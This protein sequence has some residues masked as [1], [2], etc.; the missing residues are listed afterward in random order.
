MCDFPGVQLSVFF[1]MSRV[2][3][4]FLSEPRVNWTPGKS[5]RDLPKHHISHTDK[6]PFSCSE[7][8]KC[9]SV[10]QDIIGHQR[11]HADKCPFLISRVR[12]MFHSLSAGNVSFTGKTFLNTRGF[13][14]ANALFHV[15]SAE[16]NYLKRNPG[17]TTG[18]G[19]IFIFKV[20]EMCSLKRNPG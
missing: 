2:R 12:E 17:W 3:E 6:H 10:N 16:N 11:S 4:V 14:P 19:A 20:R 13:T 9:F 7:C 15:R 18:K 8:G 5:L 1:L